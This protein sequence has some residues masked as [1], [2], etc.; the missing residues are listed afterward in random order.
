MFGLYRHGFHRLSGL[1]PCFDTP[2][3]HT[4]GP[5]HLPLAAVRRHSAGLFEPNA[6][7]ASTKAHAQ[8]LPQE[9]QSCHSSEIQR[10]APATATLKLTAG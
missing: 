6:D 4:G 3:S 2:S 5:S 9:Y 10:L 7:R 1:V 8:Q